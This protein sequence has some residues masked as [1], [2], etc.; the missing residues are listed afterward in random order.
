MDQIVRSGRARGKASQSKP[1]LT[2]V[3]PFYKNPQLVE[4]LFRS[5]RDC[6]SELDELN[7]RIVFYND[8]PDD[9]GL[10][11]ELQKAMADAK[12]LALT[13][14]ENEENLGFVGTVNA[15]FDKV[16]AEGGDI[17]LL[18]SDTVVFSGAFREM[19]EVAY[20]DP[21]IGFV[22][23]RSN[24]ATL[25]TFPHGADK[26]DLT[27]Q[28]HYARFK[29]LAHLL[30]RVSYAP[31][32]VGFCLYIKGQI[33]RDF[34]G[35]DPAYGKGYNEE[36]DL[37]CRANQYGYRAALANHAFTWHQG[38]QSFSLDGGKALRDAEN[39]RLLNSR[40]PDYLP[41]VWAYFD[42][43]EYMAERV[44]A[45]LRP[46][47]AFRQ[48]LGFDF[49][50][51]G[52]YHN[53]T[54]EA[55][56]RLLEAAAQT[57]PDDVE[58]V[59]LCS[60][61]VFDFHAMGEGGRVRWCDTHDPD[62]RLT[63]VI[64]LGQVYDKDSL[65][66]LLV[67]APVVSIFM[68]DT[69]SIDCGYL[70]IEFD[71]SL[72]SFIMKW[73][74]VV[75]GISRFTV[76]QLRRRYLIGDQTQLVPVLLSTAPEEYASSTPAQFEA[77]TPPL[78]R[79]SQ[80][81]VIG[82]KFKHKGMELAVKA[83][84]EEL[85]DTRIVALGL[86]EA[87]HANVEP[88]ASGHLSDEEVDELY[89]QA[90]A[91]VFPT[92]YEGF[93]FPVMHAM[94]RLRP[95]YVRRLPVFEEIARSFTSGQENIRWFDDDRHLVRLL[96]DSFEPWKGGPPA[97]EVQG[98]RRG[99]D[100]VYAALQKSI[101]TTSFTTISDRFRWFFASFCR[102]VHVASGPVS[103]PVAEPPIGSPSE[104]AHLDGPER[105]AEFISHHTR[106]VFLGLF[107]QKGAYKGAQIVWRLL[108]YGRLKRA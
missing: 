2:V 12:G 26:L 51:F 98:W 90:D 70:S 39:A 56:K 99:A 81:L 47:A 72:W 74:D 105:V 37:I 83:M 94:A 71:P 10:R 22:C 75:F 49:S 53:G 43:P 3:V 62:L 1:S 46:T 32:A 78:A 13:V 54:F 66:R 68:L 100:E 45:G 104:P 84:A 107:R 29:A 95:I 82:N 16:I 103:Q 19:A 41:R 33:L 11:A 17:I 77:A 55:G 87:E 18:N 65:S 60:R 108:R 50:H 28:E 9:D 7:A 106:R 85:P 5:V 89:R 23:P 59:V 27:P 101:E 76:D 92:H 25:A 97:G 31:V 42:S 21:M 38:E 69:I 79:P 52:P 102:P 67:R 14:C 48:S 80:L 88:V 63:A 91:V 86:K 30:P 4:P 73:S 40:Y 24:N 57:W 20:S 96:K 64:R 15:A 34:G 93:G 44:L 58:I 6:R 8:S 35:F 61:E 36:N